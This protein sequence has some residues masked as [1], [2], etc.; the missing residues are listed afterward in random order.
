MMAKEIMRDI[1]VI[2]TTYTDEIGLMYPSDYGYAAYPD[3][4]TTNLGSYDNPSITSNNWLYMGLSEWTITPDSSSSN[5]VFN[6][7][8]NGSFYSASADNGFSVRPVFYLNS[9]VEYSGGTGT[10]SDPFTL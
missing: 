4:W 6:L 3:A 9:N 5:N 8:N 2:Q 10:E 7:Y 1:V